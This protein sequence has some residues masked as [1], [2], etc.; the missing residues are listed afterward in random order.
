[1]EA[2][3]G[4]KD[5]ISQL[6]KQILSMEGFSTG[7]VSRQLDFGLGP[8]NDAFPEGVF[9]VG[10]IHEFV[11]PTEAHAAAANG[12]LSGLLSTLLGQ[13][14]ICLW[15]SVGRKLFP[16]A[17]KFF[18][19]EPHRVIFVDVKL[20]K[21]GLW[22]MEQ[23]LKCTALSAVV[24]ELREV[25]FAES[26]RL[27]LAVEN[28]RVTG[29]LHRQLPSSKHTLACVSRWQV[30][31]L[32]SHSSGLPGVGFPRVLVELEKIRNGRPGSWTFEWRNSRFHALPDQRPAALPATSPSN[33]RSYA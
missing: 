14:G 13:S 19:I 29:F 30:S 33:T 1:M 12:F 21:D 27:Q 16:P 20:R 2:I 17:L 31:P 11:S 9:P 7:S 5:I 22:V 4:K 8:V 23:A 28:S 32:P 6:K 3:A 15:I 25:S 24:A 18:G 26:R 10:T